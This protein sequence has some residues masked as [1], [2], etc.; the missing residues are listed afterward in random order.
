MFFRKLRNEQEKNTVAQT[1]V[2]ICPRRMQ[3]LAALQL[4]AGSA[5]HCSGIEAAKCNTDCEG[6]VVVEETLSFFLG[7]IAKYY[8]ICPPAE[9]EDYIKNL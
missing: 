1:P 5:Y 2:P 7:A 4:T 9:A 8:P 6:P 3:E